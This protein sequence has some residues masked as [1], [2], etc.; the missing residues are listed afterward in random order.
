LAIS[1]GGEVAVAAGGSLA[2]ANG[3]SVSGGTLNVDPNGTFTAGGT[4]TLASGG[5]ITGGTVTAAAFQLDSGTVTANL[6]GSGGVIKD[7]SGTVTLSG[8]NTYAGGTVVTVGT[9]IATSPSDLPVG[10]SLIIGSG[11]VFM[12]NPTAAASSATSTASR[13]VSANVAVDRTTASTAGPRL[14]IGPTIEVNPGT[15]I[16]SALLQVLR[17]PSGDADIAQRNARAL[18]WFSTSL[19]QST[20]QSGNGRLSLQPLDAVWARYGQ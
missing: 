13:G 19:L 11:G 15:I 3:V 12:F 2:I 9:L 4:V 5:S 1:G 16:D 7:T 18:A 14:V 20:D 10:T 6:A 8:K 17:R